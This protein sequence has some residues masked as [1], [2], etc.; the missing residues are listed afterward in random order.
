[1]TRYPKLR[2]LVGTIN[3]AGVNLAGVNLAG[4]NLAGVNLA[5]VNKEL[6][7]P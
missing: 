4:V 2:R 5:G 6:S 1:M 3:L 7:A